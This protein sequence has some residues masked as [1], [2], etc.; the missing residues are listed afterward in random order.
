VINQLL[1]L[2]GVSFYHNKSESE[3]DVI[4]E[5]KVALEIKTKGT[6]YDLQK[7]DKLSLKLG[8]SSAFIISNEW[9]DDPRILPAMNF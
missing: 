5:N 7:L 4:Y 2:G 6:S 1:S 9:S 3:I 8:T